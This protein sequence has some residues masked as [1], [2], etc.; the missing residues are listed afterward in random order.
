MVQFFKKTNINF[1]GQSKL[2]I[3][4]SLA[5]IL[6]S[7]AFIFVHKGLN[8]SVDFAGGTLIQM[9]FEKPVR[10]DLG[11]IRSIVNGIGLG[12]PEVKTIG[13]IVNNELQITVAKQESEI[14]SVTNAI[15]DALS[16]NYSENS[17]EIRRVESVGPKIGGELKRDAIIATILSLIAILIY[18]GFRFNLPFGVASVIP[19]FH[20]VLITLGVFIIFDLEISLTFIAAIMTIVGYSLNDTIVIFDRI[21]ENMRGGL[22]GRKFPELVNSSI[23]QTLSRT[24][25]TS[26]TTLF[27]VSALYILGSEAIKDFA[28]AMLVGVIAG[29]YSTIYIASSILVW[30]HN[31]KPVTK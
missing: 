26:V 3:S 23:N 7:A 27:V 2:A 4:I 21:R 13:Q 31:K 25:N 16:K 9:K 6:V 5:F 17:F 12:S 8:F 15:R 1:I 30:W 22:K 28:L 11:K 29:T 24:I 19:L 10:D 14:T 20:D 18:V